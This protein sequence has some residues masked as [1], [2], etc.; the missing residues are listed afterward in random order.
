MTWV[1]I[2]KAKE[3]MSGGK[4]E[5]R[6]LLTI[7]KTKMYQGPTCK[8]QARKLLEETTRNTLRLE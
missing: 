5:V 7:Y 4:N 6:P 8:T 3:R 1:V 2:N